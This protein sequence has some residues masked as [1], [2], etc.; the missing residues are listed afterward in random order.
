MG[1]SDGFGDEDFADERLIEWNG[2]GMGSFYT[3]L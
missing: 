3:I 2:D 1:E